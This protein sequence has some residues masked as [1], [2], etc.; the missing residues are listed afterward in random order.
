MFPYLS[1][2]L[3]GGFV[4]SMRRNV[5]DVSHK[6]LGS[7]CEAR[8]SKRKQQCVHFD[9]CISAAG[10]AHKPKRNNYSFY[11]LALTLCGAVHT[12]THTQTH[13]HTTHNHTHTLQYALQ[14]L[15]A[16]CFLIAIAKHES[17]FTINCTIF[18]ANCCKNG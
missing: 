4:A 5:A 6:S 8:L 17:E 9:D 15:C 3:V 13:S 2:K 7:A 14:F 12:H 10:A 11:H 16:L 1:I 18:K